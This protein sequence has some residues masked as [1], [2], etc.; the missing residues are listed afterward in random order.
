MS[1]KQKTLVCDACGDVVAHFERRWFRYVPIPVT[2]YVK[3]NL[4]TYTEIWD[5]TGPLQTLPTDEP[6]HVCEHC[7]KAVVRQVAKNKNKKSKK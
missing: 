1:E 3:L 2:P 5:V 6:I 7:L 4:K